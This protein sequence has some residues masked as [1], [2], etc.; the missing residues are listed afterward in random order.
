MACWTPYARE[1][2]NWKLETGKR[3]EMTAEMMMRDTV[4][5]D[6]A[7]NALGLT[8]AAHAEEVASP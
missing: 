8:R 4:V 1:T 5:C 7:N 6:V 3:F 2:G